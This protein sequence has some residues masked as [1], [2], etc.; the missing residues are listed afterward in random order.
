MRLHKPLLA[1]AVG[2]LMLTTMTAQPATT[3][4]LRFGH[5]WD[6]TRLMDNATVLVSDN[7]IV[8]V[9][10]GN[11]KVPAGA[12]EIDLRK[13]TAI[14][15]LIDLHTHI[16]YYWDHAEGT[17]PLRQATPR[18]TADQT[19]EAAFDNARK[20]L[21]TGVTTIRDLGASGGVD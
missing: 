4:A 11:T 9:S 14:P 13:Y 8:A 7:K 3:K 10:S 2:L 1:S 20:T 21:E 18:R 15:G 6:G 19:F 16:T 12:E 17:T 5:L